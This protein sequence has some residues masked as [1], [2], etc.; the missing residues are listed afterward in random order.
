[1]KKWLLSLLLMALS[2]SSWSQTTDRFSGIQT[3]LAIKAPV[4]AVS[5]S[6]LTLSGAQTVNGTAVVAG[7]RVLVTSQTDATENGIYNVG[8][9]AWQRAAD[10]DGNR[11]VADGTLVT[12]NRTTGANTFYQVDTTADPVVI[13]TSTINFIQVSDPNVQWPI[14]TYET[15]AG[16]TTVDIT[17]SY[18]PGDV[19]RYGAAMDGSTNDKTA[20]DNAALQCSQGGAAIFVPRDSDGMAI[21]AGV[22]VDEDCDINFEPG[23][24]ILYTGSSEE[25]ILTF[26]GDTSTSASRRT[27]TNIAV[28]RNSQSDWTNEANICIKARNM[29]SSYVH[30]TE[31]L[32]CTIG[33]QL[34]GNSQGFQFTKVVAGELRNNKVG[35]DLT[36][37]DDSGVGFCNQNTIFLGRVTVFSGVNQGLDRFGFRMNSVASTPRE[38]NSNSIFGGGME[39]NA[40]DASGTARAILINYGIYNHFYGLRDENNDAPFMETENAA[41]WNIAYGVMENASSAVRNDGDYDNNFVFASREEPYQRLGTIAT[42]PEMAKTAVEYDGAGAIYVPGMSLRSSSSTSKFLGL[43][44]ITVGG[45]Y[46]DIPASR[47]VGMMLDTSQC[48][49]FTLTRDGVSG[50]GGRVTVMAYDSGGTQLTDGGGGHPYVVGVSGKTFSYTSANQSYGTG[51][52]SDSEQFFSVGDDV[53]TAWVGIFGG[54]A[55]ARMRSLSIRCWDGYSVSLSQ[56]LVADGFPNNELAYATSPPASVGAGITYTTGQVIWKKDVAAG[57]PPGWLCT[58]GGAGGT[59]VF[60][61]MADLDP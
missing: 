45:D 14:T 4:K 6:N 34:M 8:A 55:T 40:S 53:K 17:D 7:D 30:I 20:F 56:G 32:N 33:L 37:D 29:V 60:K 23:A 13:D 24:F 39:M 38:C 42:T 47:G 16:L 3:G 43:S 11:D 9:T 58:T 51:S 5:V 1:M 26:G 18:E 49:R 41:E 15:T 57:G 44:L 52:D 35:L 27:Y 50:R 2:A 31:A 12:V 46:L 36:N 28:R 22:T 59:A 25:A 21:N 61:E 54:T 10:F 48:K 19:R